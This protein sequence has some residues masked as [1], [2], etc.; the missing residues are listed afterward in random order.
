MNIAYKYTCMT[1]HTMTQH[2]WRC[3]TGSD[4]TSGVVDLVF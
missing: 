3:L 2:R 1:Q 4:V